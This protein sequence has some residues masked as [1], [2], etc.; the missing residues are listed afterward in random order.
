MLA[1][2]PPTDTARQ[3][4]LRA[5]AAELRTAIEAHTADFSDIDA[6]AA[7]LGRA[8]GHLAVVRPT[9]DAESRSPDTGRHH[10]LARPRS[11]A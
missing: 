8:A 10:G 9:D 11:L 3:A 4:A 1:R 7:A 5:A 6:V 2:T